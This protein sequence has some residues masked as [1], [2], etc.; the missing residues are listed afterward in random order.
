MCVCSVSLCTCAFQYSIGI[1]PN[2]SCIITN[3]IYFTLK[4]RELDCINAQTVYGK[5]TPIM[6]QS[7]F[8][9]AW[10]VAVS[11]WNK[12]G[13]GELWEAVGPWGTVQH[14]RSFAWPVL[15]WYIYTLEC[16]ALLR[17]QRRGVWSECG[18]H[19]A[20][21]NAIAVEG[22]LNQTGTNNMWTCLNP[23]KS[24]GVK[25][26]LSEILH[27]QWEFMWPVARLCQTC[28]AYSDLR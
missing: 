7:Y 12:R 3:A 26:F 10:K 1:H 21:W 6:P 20:S 16:G 9:F 23:R 2:T 15:V 27:A 25:Y 11:G 18:A 8:Q 28:A 14:G 22:R 19:S 4:L 24:R 17:M 5:G 13:I